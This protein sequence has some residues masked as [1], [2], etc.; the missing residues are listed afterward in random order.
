MTRRELFGVLAL[1]FVTRLPLLAIDAPTT[2]PSFGGSPVLLHKGEVILTG[3]QQRVLVAC[4]RCHGMGVLCAEHP[5][6]PMHHV[7]PNGEICSEA[8][9]PCGLED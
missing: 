7:L 8:G 6:Q 9:I 2:L 5:D 1:P 3:A 4:A